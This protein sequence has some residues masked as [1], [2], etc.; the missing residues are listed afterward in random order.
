[1]PLAAPSQRTRTRIPLRASGSA[2]SPQ[3]LERFRI[4]AWI[5]LTFGLWDALGAVRILSKEDISCLRT[6]QLNGRS[7]LFWSP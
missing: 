4:K 2:L 6:V 5:L 7:K 3:A 1:M